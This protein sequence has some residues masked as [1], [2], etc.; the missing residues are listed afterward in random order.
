MAANMAQVSP[1]AS[2]RRAR[3]VVA[4]AAT[5]PLL[6]LVLMPVSLVVGLG[7]PFGPV[8]R[9]GQGP[10]FLDLWAALAILAAGILALPGS[11]MAYRLRGAA[12]AAALLL[13]LLIL[14]GVAYA[15]GRWIE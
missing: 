9:I 8:M 2:R 10:W 5:L 13:W 4:L 11:I 6:V 1:E 15:G 7:L 3:W 12:G 14:S